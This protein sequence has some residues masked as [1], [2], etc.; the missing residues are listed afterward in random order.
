MLSIEDSTVS[1]TGES[2][3]STS[4]GGFLN[5]L[6]REL[7]KQVSGISKLKEEVKN[8]VPTVRSIF[9]TQ[10]EFR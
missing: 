8:L 9:F 6:P 4:V 7:E 10:S 3:L 5:D 2:I 1:K